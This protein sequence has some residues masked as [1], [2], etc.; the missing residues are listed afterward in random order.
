M[1]AQSFDSKFHTPVHDLQTPSAF[2]SDQAHGLLTWLQS[3]PTTTPLP[4][5]PRHSLSR[6]VTSLHGLKFGYGQSN[7]SYKVTIFDPSTDVVHCTFVLRAQPIGRLLP[8]AHRLDREYKV[9]NALWSTSVPVPRVYA[10][11]ADGATFIPGRQFYIMEYIPGH[12]FKD[13]SMPDLAPKDRTHVFLEALRV[14]LDIANLDIYNVGLSKLSRPSPH[15]LRRQV[16]IWHTQIQRSQSSVPKLDWSSLNELYNRLVAHPLYSSD[17]GSKLGLVHGD[18]RIDNLIF[19]RRHSDGCLTCVA[20][21]DWELVSL[22]DPLADFAQLLN[23]FFMPKEASQVPILKPNS[24]PHPLPGGIP[25]HEDLIA[26]YTS[27]TGPV[28]DLPVYVAVSLF[29]LSGVLVG[30]L[31]RARQ[32][33]ASSAHAETL[34]SQVLLFA[35]GG[36]DALS[37]NQTSGI[38]DSQNKVVATISS[39]LESRLEKF[40]KEHILPLEDDYFKHVSSE[41]RWDCWKPMETLKL[42]AKSEGLWNLFLPKSLGGSLTSAEY[43]PL[44]SI[45][46]RCV[47]ASEVFNCSAPDTGKLSPSCHVTIAHGSNP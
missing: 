15:W 35:R 18:F 9:L 43:A 37:G 7:P 44:A 33:N 20:V 12:V 39:D 8:G 19:Q 25:T 38:T 6:P 21:L 1:V 29:R 31:A 5:F 36:L 10:F 11:C 16:D 2:T 17:T 46:G 4:P 32:G 47:Y 22:G 41:H 30:V 26:H 23:P 34:G 24:F 14:L 3:L 27:R 45:M 42:K 28:P 40:M 13:L